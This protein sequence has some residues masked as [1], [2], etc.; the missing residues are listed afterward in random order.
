MKRI[1]YDKLIYATGKSGI[2]LTDK[3][4]KKNNLSTEQKSTQ[5]GVRFEAPQK[6]FQKLV[7]LAYDFKL[8]QK[9]TD[10]VSVRTFC[11]NND[12]AYVAVEET[13]GDISYNGHARKEEKYRNNMTNFGI[14]ME[15]KGIDNPF[16][17]ARDLVGKCQKKSWI[18]KMDNKFNQVGLYYSPKGFRQSS[19]TAEQTKIDV[20]D[21]YNDVLDIFKES[22]G[23]YSNHIFKFIED[24]NK[25]FEFGDDW[26]IYIPEIKY[27]TP[28]IIVN[29][30][31]LS[32]ID[33]PN[34]HIAGD[35]LSARGIVVSASH[36]L[37]IAKSLLQQD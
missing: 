20:Y 34:V 23:E 32:L 26:G 9:P 13:Y 14:I 8:Y 10:N 5:V 17:W 18:N 37:L 12:C 31:D 27:V 7:D 22:F 6:Y 11:T 33:Y 16:K 21:A 35:S 25:I 19:N 1:K 15:I 30:N 24:M 36:G 3:L 29:Y 2:D 28:E 4:I